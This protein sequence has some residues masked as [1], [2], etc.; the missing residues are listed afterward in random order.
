MEKVIEEIKKQIEEIK[1]D[2][3]MSYPKA[4]IQINAPLA[5]I[6]LSMGVKLDTLEWVLRLLEMGDGDDR[7]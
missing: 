6:Q 1:K 4:T 5:L 3:R 2:T 7:T